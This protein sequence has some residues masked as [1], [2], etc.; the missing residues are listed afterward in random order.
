M[1]K[2]HELPRLKSGA[3]P[4]GGVSYKRRRLMAIHK[5]LS[6]WEYFFYASGS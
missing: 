2:D 5:A 1:V 6:Q 4:L 3:L